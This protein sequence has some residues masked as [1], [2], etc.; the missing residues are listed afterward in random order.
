MNE[1]QHKTTSCNNFIKVLLKMFDVL[2]IW[3][4]YEVLRHKK[5]IRNRN[6]KFTV[7][8]ADK[9]NTNSVFFPIV[10]LISSH[11]RCVHDC[12]ELLID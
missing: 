6:M 8:C 9:K 10:K 2:M 3:W 12:N 5:N 4:F 7:R 1:A 11:K